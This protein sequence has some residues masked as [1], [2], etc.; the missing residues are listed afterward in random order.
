ML[1]ELSSTRSTTDLPG[2]S[3]VTLAGIYSGIDAGGEII[4]GDNI[5]V[6]FGLIGFPTTARPGFGE[7]LCPAFNGSPV[8]FGDAIAGVGKKPYELVLS[9]RSFIFGVGVGVG[10]VSEDLYSR[11]EP[12]ILAILCGPALLYCQLCHSCGFEWCA[13]QYKMKAKCNLFRPMIERAMQA[14]ILRLSTSCQA[15]SRGFDAHDRNNASVLHNY[16]IKE[17]DSRYTGRIINSGYINV[18]SPLC[19]R[20]RNGTYGCDK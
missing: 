14:S 3:A 17:Q 8:L 16:C 13:L 2:I 4:G 6:N 5:V 1:T 19:P 11:H 20:N 15:H 18:T 12:R 10:S 9:S 7:S